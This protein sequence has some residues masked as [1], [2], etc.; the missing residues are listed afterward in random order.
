MAAMKWIAGLHCRWNSALFLFDFAGL[1]SFCRSTEKFSGH[2]NDSLVM[3]HSWSLINDQSWSLQLLPIRNSSPMLHNASPI[4]AHL[5]FS[6][7]GLS[8][9]PKSSQRPEW[10]WHPYLEWRK[11]LIGSTSAEHLE[12]DLKETI[13]S[14][15]VPSFPHFLIVA[16]SSLPRKYSSWPQNASFIK[17]SSWLGFLLS[18]EKPCQKQIPGLLVPRLLATISAPKT[19]QANLASG[20]TQRQRF[21]KKW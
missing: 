7:Q 19:R 14:N 12:S 1:L 3:I 5:V 9:W 11:I 20:K 6:L 13:R 21:R 15:D 2:L 18:L 10:R 17:M 16:L 8:S 4:Y